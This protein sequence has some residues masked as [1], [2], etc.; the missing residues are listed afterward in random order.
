MSDPFDIRYFIYF[1]SIVS[2]NEDMYKYI[3]F[4]KNV[5]RRIR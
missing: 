4:Y 2:F 3:L 5:V 1:V